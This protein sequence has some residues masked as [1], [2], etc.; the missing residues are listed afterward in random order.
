MINQYIR[1]SP[2]TFKVVELVGFNSFNAVDIKHPPQNWPLPPPPKKKHAMKMSFQTQKKIEKNNFCRQNKQRKTCKT[3]PPYHLYLQKPFEH[4]RLERGHKAGTL[5]MG[6]RNPQFFREVTRFLGG[7]CLDSYN[8][9]FNL[10]NVI[11]NLSIYTRKRLPDTLVVQGI[12]TPK[13]LKNV[14]C[15]S[16][17]NMGYNH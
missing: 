7:R 3:N 9:I 4:V 11:H 12:W 2:S 5:R 16:P 6:S 15:W 17:E 14:G 10:H 13:P 1:V 8:V